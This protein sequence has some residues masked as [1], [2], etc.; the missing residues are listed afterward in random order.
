MYRIVLSLLILKQHALLTAQKYLLT[1]FIER[2]TSLSAR[3]Q[4]YSNH[5]SHNT[6][7][8]LIAVSPTGA[9]IFISKCWGGRAS[10]KHITSHCG[11]LDHLI[12]GDVVMADRGFEIAEDL[13][14]RVT[15]TVY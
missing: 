8:F 14:L 9:V 3:S 12:N 5:K 4:T 11:F 2:A 10:D 15:S 13:A 7:K 6:A 1:V